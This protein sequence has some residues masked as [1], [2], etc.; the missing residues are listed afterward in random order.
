MQAGAVAEATRPS[1]TAVNRQTAQT[2]FM[3]WGFAR[4]TGTGMILSKSKQNSTFED[5][6]E[7]YLMNLEWESLFSVVI[8]VD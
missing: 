3:P 8:F 5:F 2:Q 4:P 1:S 6:Y 7:A